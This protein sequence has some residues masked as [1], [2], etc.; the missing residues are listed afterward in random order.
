MSGSEDISLLRLRTLF[1]VAIS[2]SLPTFLKAQSLPTG[3]ATY[4]LDLSG[5]PCGTISTNINPTSNGYALATTAKLQIN[6][7]PFAFSRNGVIDRQLNPVKETLNGAVNGSAVLFALNTAAGKYAINISANGKQ[8]SNSLAQHAH[9]VFLPDF[10]PVAVQVLITTLATNQ[11]VWVLIPKQTGL[12]Y[13]VQVAQK[14]QTQ[15]TLDGKSVTVRHI[16]VTIAGVSSDIFSTP[17]GLFLQEE[18]PQQGFA[19]VRNGFKLV[20]PTTGAPSAST[21][22]KTSNPGTST[23]PPPQQ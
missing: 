19:L 16:S 3:P 15:G 22:P 4:A 18:T 14:P 12:L 10:D 11:S 13:P 9:T 1:F 21:P 20:A 23:P 17:T 5:H 7:T 8:Y 6:T 2:L